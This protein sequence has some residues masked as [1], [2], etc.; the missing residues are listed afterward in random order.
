MAL[1][2][3]RRV[4]DQDISW[5]CNQVA[6]RGGVVSVDTLGSGISMDQAAALVK[7]SSS[8]SGAR[9]VGI[10][11]SQVVNLDLT[12]QHL[13]QHKEE[14]QLGSK[15]TILTKGEVTTNHLVSGIT[16]ANGDQAYL[17]VD[18]R[19]TNST[20]GAAANPTIGMFTSKKDE[21]GYAKVSV[22]LP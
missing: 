14:V 1:K 13:N 20:S 17:G 12:R 2:P 22:N 6:E 4:V 9:P 11:T 21:D 10:L 16:V 15:V 5:F 18:G 3:D 7:Y 19:I 8:A